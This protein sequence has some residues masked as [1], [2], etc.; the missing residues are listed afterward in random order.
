M[1]K[2]KNTQQQETN[3]R[4]LPNTL[5]WR[6]DPED[7]RDSSQ[8]RDTGQSDA[9]AALQRQI[10]ELEAGR[11]QDQ[12]NLTALMSQPNYTQR[13]QFQTELDT[14]G[15]PDPI[16]EPDA[17]AREMTRRM[18]LAIEGRAQAQQ[19]EASQQQAQSRKVNALWEEFQEKYPDYSDKYEQVEFAA[20]KVAEK[21]AAKGLDVNKYMFGTSSLFME[22]VAGELEKIFPSKSTETEEGDTSEDDAS[23]G[24]F[25][26]T[27]SGGKPVAAPESETDMF[28][29]LK[30][31]Q[32]KT[33]FYR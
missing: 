16:Q 24:I 21:A 1:P 23:I 33:G 32:L 11:K 17:Y 29:D 8:T 9:V 18:N 27:A 6:D 3:F 15:L 31:W 19:Y 10:A 7:T 30:E 13:P 14:K 28:D 5:P 4:G 26:G 12:R 22:D 20:R 2:R 25:G